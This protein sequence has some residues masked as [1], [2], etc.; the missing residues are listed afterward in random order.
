M[1]K[2]SLSKT[3]EWPVEY[4]YIAET[5]S[6]LVT[7]KFTVK[8]NRDRSILDKITE[9]DEEGNQKYNDVDA[10]KMVVKGWKDI[11]DE[12]G[13]EYAYSEEALENL[14][15]QCVGLAQTFVSQWSTSLMKA[16][17]KNLKR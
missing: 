8:F 14:I 2:L 10:A 15:D 13:N 12:N 17:E 6:E 16:Q 1:F 11:Q 4:S 3:Y 5:G 7:S 9:K